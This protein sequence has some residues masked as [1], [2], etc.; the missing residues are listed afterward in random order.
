M[1]SLIGCSVLLVEDEPL[2]ALDVQDCLQKEGA[3]V[4]CAGKL[5]DALAFAERPDLSVAIID[6]DLRGEDGESVCDRLVKRGVPFLFY[7]GWN[8]SDLHNVCDSAPVL[9]K[10]VPCETI[11]EAVQ[12]LIEAG[13]GAACPSKVARAADL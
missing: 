7:S 12:D 10:P 2:I 8:A 11:V 1:L 9:S 4:F 5:A 13:H 3:R 6:F